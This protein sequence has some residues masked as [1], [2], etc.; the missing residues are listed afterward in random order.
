MVFGKPHFIKAET[1]PCIEA[2]QSAALDQDS[3]KKG[4]WATWK[5]SHMKRLFIVFCILNIFMHY[6]AVRQPFPAQNPL[7]RRASVYLC[8]AD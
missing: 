2:K 8:T 5:K 3:S 6:F 7:N 1:N 4:T